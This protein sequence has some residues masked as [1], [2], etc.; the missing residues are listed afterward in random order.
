M[1]TTQLTGCSVCIQ[2]AGGTLCAAHIEPGGGVDG[3]TLARQLAGRVG[4]VVGGAFSNLPGPTANPFHVFGRDSGTLPKGPRG[5]H[6]RANTTGDYASVL[7]LVQNGEWR[8]YAQECRD[9]K[10]LGPNEIW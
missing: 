10:V 5:Y 2:D 1:L 6:M 4:Q 3:T 8:V 7:G 9:D